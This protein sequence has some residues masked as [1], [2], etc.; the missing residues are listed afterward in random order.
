M[1]YISLLSAVSERTAARMRT[2]LFESIIS[3]DIQF[4]DS[5]KTGELV[6]RYGGRSAH[7]LTIV[8]DSGFLLSP[9]LVLCKDYFQI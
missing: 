5:H 4:F 2:R 3:Q 9:L 6:N 8:S 1:C 7:V